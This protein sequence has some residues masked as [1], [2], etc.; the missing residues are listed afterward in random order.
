MRNSIEA[1]ITA[2]Q[3]FNL[4]VPGAASAPGTVVKAR[5]VTGTFVADE[6]EIEGA[7]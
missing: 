3:F 6:L 2:A 5:L 4:V 7:R 1:A